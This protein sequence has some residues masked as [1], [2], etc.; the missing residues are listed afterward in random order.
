M[1]VKGRK[2]EE[3]KKRKVVN[4][5]AVKNNWEHLAGCD[6]A[7]LLQFQP[8]FSNKCDWSKLDGEDWAYL[9]ARQPQFADMCDWEKLSGHHWFWLL[10]KQPEF[11]NRCDWSKL[12]GGDWINLIAARPEFID[13]CEG[14]KFGAHDIVRIV[15]Q[16]GKIGVPMA[17][18][19]LD[20]CDF[21]QLTASDWSQ[22]L[23][24][25]P[26]LVGKFESIERD[27]SKDDEIDDVEEI[28]QGSL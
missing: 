17:A 12:D 18:L 16:C 9:L 19:H 27:W 21:S 20:E 8:R 26:D 22:V 1:L 15:R 10:W 6:W 23:V 11:A 13:R 2:K 5:M 24:L 3:Y 28:L 14:S 25:R 7:Q 4:T